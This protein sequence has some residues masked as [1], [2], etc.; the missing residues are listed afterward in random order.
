MYIKGY[1]KVSS[2]LF[3]P[4]ILNQHPNLI[5]PASLP[6]LILSIHSIC[7]YGKG[8]RR[9]VWEAYL[10]NVIRISLKWIHFSFYIFGI[11][12]DQQMDTYIGVHTPNIWHYTIYIYSFFIY[13]ICK[14][15]IPKQQF[16]RPQKHV[17]CYYDFHFHFE[18]R[19]Q[20][21][22]WLMRALQNLIT[23]YN[24]CAFIS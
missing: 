17:S 2:M 1:C 22:K 8:H 24:S 10:F 11:N 21:S 6:I 5:T 14:I 12:L 23:I 19:W 4:K 9:A 3:R 18:I 13:F 20:H 16:R 7:S 15:S